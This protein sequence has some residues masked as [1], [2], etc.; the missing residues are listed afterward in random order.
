MPSYLSDYPHCADRQEE[1]FVFAVNSFLKQTF[2]DAELIIIADGCEKTEKLYRKYFVNDRVKFDMVNKGEYFDGCVRN[3]GLEI[4]SGE[5]I[6]YLDAD[7]FIGK[8]HLQIIN[9]SLKTEDNIDWFYYDDFYYIYKNQYTRANLFKKRAVQIKG[10]M[11][12]GTCSFGHKRALPVKW[13]TGY[14]HDHEFVKELMKYTGKK[15]NTPEYFIC[16]QPGLPIFDLDVKD[17]IILS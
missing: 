9:D 14:G 7:D 1:R 6:V 2:N 5:W 3:R 4:A 15:I 10:K 8:N 17:L 16:H 12:I 13:T 11:R